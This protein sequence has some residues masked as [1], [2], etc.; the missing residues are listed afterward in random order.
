M[1]DIEEETSLSLFQKKAIYL[2]M[3]EY[4]RLYA[5]ALEEAK[6][7]E[8]SCKNWENSWMK[9]ISFYGTIEN[10][11]TKS[12]S[13]LHENDP[14]SKDFLI[15]LENSWFN[16]GKA[17]ESISSTSTATTD[18]SAIARTA[19][20]IKVRELEGKLSHQ[21]AFALKAQEKTDETALELKVAL[22][23][24]DRLRLLKTPTEP[25]LVPAAD[26]AQ[27]ATVPVDTKVKDEGISATEVLEIRAI[28]DS[29]AETIETLV[30]EKYT[31]QHELDNRLVELSHERARGDVEKTLR[32]QRKTAESYRPNLEKALLEIESLQASRRVFTEQISSEEEKRRTALE[33]DMR[34][35]EQDLIRL[36]TH[37]DTLQKSL[38]MA[39]AKATQDRQTTHHLHTLTA[40]QQQ[41][42]KSLEAAVHRLQL[43][44]GGGEA[45]LVDYFT[46]PDAPGNPYAESAAEIIQ[47]RADKAALE[48]V[49]SGFERGSVSAAVEEM[50]EEAER[51]DVA[52][53]EMQRYKDYFG[54]LGQE[55]GLAKEVR[56]RQEELDALRIEMKKL[57]GGSDLIAVEL[58]SMAKAYE[59]LTTQAQ[60]DIVKLGE[61]EDQI[62]KLI[63]EKARL[64]QKVISLNKQVT[65]LGNN[66]IAQKRQLD[67]QLE[68]IRKYGEMEK[69]LSQQLNTSEQKIASVAPTLESLQH[70][71]DAQILDNATIKE[72]AKSLHAKCETMSNL[73]NEKSEQ[74]EIEKEITRKTLEQSSTIKKKYDSFLKDNGDAGMQ[75]QVDQYRLL[76]MCQS[77]N[78]DF[79]SHVLL[80]CMHTFCKSCIDDRLDSRQRKCPTC[81]VPFGQQDVKQVY[82]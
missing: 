42:I 55:V 4:K 38:D 59:A 17:L 57:K 18:D 69:N 43:E 16:L 29:R 51:R 32:Q 68:L 25:A 66:Q 20:E 54:V 48:R 41:R 62:A 80:K 73:L 5:S 31:L 34:K 78:N 58:D 3:I 37:R 53:K 76:L 39:T 71:L 74:M 81:S 47:L 9:I 46:R 26:V 77:C 56:D 36:R 50:R 1:E 30:R 28:A 61:K 22:K 27:A 21:T 67:K 15:L 2:Q 23:K 24:I 82:L 44:I 14:A 11:L 49:V 35:F 72:Q 33:S 63:G 6:G 60:E 12:D 70:K 40:A 13:N 10:I 64:E 8:K 65:T 7:L 45:A 19:L 52:E 79:K 75:Q